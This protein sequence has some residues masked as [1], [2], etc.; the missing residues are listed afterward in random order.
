VGVKL[1][2]ASR[3]L[4]DGL[5]QGFLGPDQAAAFE[6]YRQQHQPVVFVGPYE[7]H[8]N[9]I[10]WRENQATVVEVALADDGGIDLHHL[11]ALLQ[12]PAYQGRLRIGS[13]SAASNVT[14]MRSPVY[15]LA[16]LL[17]SYDALAF[18]DYAACAPYVPIDM[19]P[20]TDNAAEGAFL[21]AVFVSPHKFLGGPGSSGLLIFNQRCYHTELPPSI[22][23]GGTV[24][25]VGPVDHDFVHD[26][27]SREKAGTP[28]ILQTVRAALAFEVKSAVGI[29]HI[30][31][32]EAE[33][34]RAAFTRWGSNPRIEILGNPDPARRIGIVS[35]N[36]KD[37]EGQYLHPRFVTTLLNDLFGIQS[38]AGCSCAGP[39][40]HQLLGI[41]QHKAEAYRAWITRGY[42]GVKPGW[43]RLGF[44]YA[45]DEAELE[46]LLSCVE[47][48]AE[49]G[50]RFVHQYRF[51]ARSGSW[52][53]KRWQP[54]GVRFSLRDALQTDR[55]GPGALS[56]AARKS[57]YLAYLAQAEELARQAA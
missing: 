41:D 43:C 39:Y 25:Y 46:Y 7:H 6:A 4:V 11:E 37:V 23:G 33:M 1:P 47:F 8:S 24:D 3:A 15:E 19:N 2:A 12:D 27:E 14:G 52:Q 16:E 48:V 44:H 40:G 29:E 35:F 50:H 9:E 5:L 31:R 56:E 51:D 10:S 13:F 20:S 54:R 32:R 36:L 18:F 49:H 57:L 26:I 28:G 38:R 22:A 42:H 30:E 45:F 34:L 55:R 17:H 53:H 21:D